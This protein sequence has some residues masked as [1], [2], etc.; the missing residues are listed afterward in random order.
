MPGARRTTTIGAM[1][2]VG[3]AAWVPLEDLSPGVCIRTAGVDEDHVTLLMET[4]GEWPPVLATRGGR[5]ID[6]THRL[7]AARR[8][9]LPNLSVT[10]FDGTDDEAFAE[11]VHRNVAHGLPLSFHDRVEAL[12]H[13]LRSHRDWSDRRLASIC[14]VSP[15]TVAPPRG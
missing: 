10:W 9:G 6:G 12:R 4:P 14:A 3:G 13:L 15:R 11:A 2:T 7:I 5:V 1:E 8:C